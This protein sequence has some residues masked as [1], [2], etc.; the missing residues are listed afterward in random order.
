MLPYMIPLFP[1]LA[2]YDSFI[3]PVGP[4]LPYMLPYGSFFSLVGQILPYV[5][6]IPLFP[7][8]AQYYPICYHMIPLFPQL[9]QYYPSSDVALSVYATE[10][11]RLSINSGNIRLTGGLAAHIYARDG[12]KPV[13]IL[14]VVMVSEQS[15]FLSIAKYKFEM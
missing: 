3:S 7:Q 13:K 12:K 1:Q 15:I 5:Y 6:M 2:Q 11:P 9:A 4:I 8:L 14:S 10:A